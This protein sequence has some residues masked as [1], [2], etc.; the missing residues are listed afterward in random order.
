[1]FSRFVHIVACISTSIGFIVN[2]IPLY[3][4]NVS[5]AWIDSCFV[6][7]LIS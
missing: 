5:I 7:P 3:G 1:M 2:D 6:Y 4:Y